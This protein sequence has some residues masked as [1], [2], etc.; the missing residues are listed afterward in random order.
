[1]IEA[2]DTAA[3]SFTNEYDGRLNGGGTSIIN[4]FV[5]EKDEDGSESLD[6]EKLYGEIGSAR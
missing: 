3:V 2:G 6:W 5:Y 1:M 4:H